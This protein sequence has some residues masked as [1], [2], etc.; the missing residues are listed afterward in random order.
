MQLTLIFIG[1]NVAVFILQ[2]F[3]LFSGMSFMPATFT[4]EPWTIVTSIFI[5]GIV[6]HL[7]LNILGLFMFGSVVEKELGK[8]KWFILYLF[9]GFSGSLAYILLSPS[10]FIPALGASG[11]IFGLIGGAAILKPK[12]VIWTAY[13]PFPM[14]IAA[15]GWGIA[16]FIGMF[17]IDTI[18]QSAHIGGLIGGAIIALVLLLKVD[19][20]YVIFLI[21]LPIAAAFFVCSTLPSE[22]SAYTDVPRGFEL[23]SSQNET[24]F[25][26]NKYSNGENWIVSMTL[27]SEEQFN[28]AIYS[29]YLASIV[30]YSYYQ[31]FGE[32]CNETFNYSV[33]INNDT[34]IIAGE[35]CSQ[36]FRALA[37]LC[38]NNVDV[39]MV[40]F[41]KTNA[42]IGNFVSCK[43]LTS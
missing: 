35:L 26:M 38:L 36:K 4:N 31:V 33:D 9:A 12:M 23:K 3:G 11:A 29:R 17:G 43:G 16:E 25:K 39:Q 8:L 40:E 34:A 19:V 20:K 13:G 6:Q 18:A 32:Q 7:M 41:Y 28:L 14:I 2:Q 15:I 1:I 27:P 10:P 30:P 24:N 21:V 42:V 22:I 37:A 5:H